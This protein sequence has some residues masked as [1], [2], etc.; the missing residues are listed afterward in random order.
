MRYTYSLLAFAVTALAFP[1]EK[2][3]DNG[4]WV[5]GKYEDKGTGFDNSNWKGSEIVSCLKMNLY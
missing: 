2:P 5:P 4:K 1:T 3:A